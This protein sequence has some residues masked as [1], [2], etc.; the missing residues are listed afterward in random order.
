MR[1][2]RK[3][4]S[5][6]AADLKTTDPRRSHG[7]AE[8]KPPEPSTVDA[9]ESEACGCAGEGLPLL[10]EMAAD[11][12]EMLAVTLL[13]FVF[14]GFFCGKVDCWNAGMDVAAQVLGEDDGALF[15]SR[16]LMFGRAVQRERQG[17]FNFLPGHCSRIAED[18]IE[19]LEL[20]KAVRGGKPGPVEVALLTLARSI[21][22]PRLAAAAWSFGRLISSLAH[23]GLPAANHADRNRPVG[24]IL[25]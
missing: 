19:A 8:P 24:T 2:A 20:L 6:K 16:V 13:R 22:T 14:A 23:A 10:C 1:W 4:A 15:Y 12:I 17:N 18:E 11:E 5:P 21:E 3:T 9:R 25:H 7:G